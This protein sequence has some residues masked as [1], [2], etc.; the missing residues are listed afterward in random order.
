M[1]WR[2]EVSIGEGIPPWYGVAWWE[3]FGHRAV[4]YVVGVHWVMRWVREAYWVV[5][6]PPKWGW[7]IEEDVLAGQRRAY[8]E[9][10][11]DEARRAERAGRVGP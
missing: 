10:R 1:R 8:W 11:E 5:A 2:K 4:C 9:G 6:S 3:D 7:Y